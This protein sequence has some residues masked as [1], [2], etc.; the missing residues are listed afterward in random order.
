MQHEAIFQRLDEYQK[1]AVLDES[2]V[3]VVNAHVGSG[4][5]TVLISKI[6]YLHE[7]KHVRYEDMI[8]LTFTNKAANEI[9]DRLMAMDASIDESALEGFGT[10]HSVA[11]T[12]L[13]RK[14]PIEKLGYTAD[15]LVIEPDEELDMA[16]QIIFE[17]KLKIKYK[18]RLKKR[19]EK[20]MNSQDE[21]QRVSSYQDDLFKLVALLKREK[22]KQNKMTFDDLIQNAIQLLKNHSL[23]MQWLIIDEVQDSDRLQLAF[24]Q[25]I[26]GENTKLFAVGDPNQVIYSWRGSTFNVF[27]TLIN[28]YQAQELT[29]PLN[30]RS[31]DSILGA[32]RYFLQFGDPLKGTRMAGDQIVIKNHYNAFQ[33]ACY[34][35]DRLRMLHEEGIPYKEMAVFYRLQSQSEVLEAVFEKNQIPYEVSLKKTIRDI[36]V[37]NWLIKLLRFSINPKDMSSGVYVLSHK[38]YG[39]KLSEKEANKWVKQRLE[40]PEN[41]ENQVHLKNQSPLFE[42]MRNFVAIFTSPNS[43]LR[44]DKNSEISL[45]SAINH[46]MSFVYPSVDSLYHY[47][48]LDHHI[49][50]TSATYLVDKEAIYTL[51]CLIMDYSKESKLPFIEG[52][53]AFIN[54]SALYGV[55]ILKIE[56]Q[57]DQDTVKL[58]TLHASKG[59]EFSHVFITGVNQGLIPLHTRN[60]LEEEEERRLFFVGM[61]RAKDYL[62]L[63]YYT[64]PDTIRTLSGASRYIQMLPAKWIQNEAVKTETVNL[65]ALKK[66]IQRAKSENADQA[67]GVVTDEVI[68][69][70]T[71][72]EWANNQKPRQVNHKKYGQGTVIHEDEDMIT[73]EFNNY[74]KK[75]FIKAFSALDFL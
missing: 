27:Y 29:L 20:V 55:N 15:F 14:L 8:V 61:T 33:E 31:S 25:A 30:Y 73:V 75:E 36:P 39:D 74:G 71:D 40:S 41:Q 48:E 59:L 6:I 22:V 24:M 11:L 21:S 19:L 42:M 38:D 50:P 54:S 72:N 7:T 69:Q 23:N 45:E 18:N 52:L 2:E 4:K 35:A 1:K 65:Q 32:A 70:K 28:T 51:L 49:R 53:K 17:A 3:C 34:L 66:A 37:L 56:I 13:K 12:L 16:L 10:F 62:E 67:K 43:E 26:K 60:D 46:D 57:S 5:T 63:S 47:F 64:N 44:P 9:K 68:S 58:M